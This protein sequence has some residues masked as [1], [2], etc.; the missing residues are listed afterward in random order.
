[1]TDTNK[2]LASTF[3]F[4][5]EALDNIFETYKEL[6]EKC[7][8]GHSDK[9][10][11]FWFLTKS[12]DIFKVEQDPE[13]YSVKPTMLVPS[14]ADFPMIPI[15][16][17]LPE[18]AE[19]RRILLPLFTPQ[20][21]A[22]QEGPVRDV[23]RD[24][25]TKF[26]ASDSTDAT[27][28]FARPLPTIFFSR[29]AGFPEKDWPKFDAWVD[30][31]LYRR[32]QEPER[33]KTASREV[34]SYFDNLIE[35]YKGR[36]TPEADTGTIM[37]Y[38]LEAR[39]NGQPLT[40][41]ELL[42]YCYLMFLGGLDTTAWAIRASLWYLAQNL[43]AQRYLRENPEAVPA[44]AEEF[45]RTM[46]PVQAMG[47]T[48]KVDTTIRGQEI[49]SGERVV[50]L[51]G[52]GNR[53]PEVYDHPDEIQIDRKHNKH[54]AFG[55]GHHRCLGS[56]LGRREVVIALE[57]FLSIVPEFTLGDTS[58][59]WHGVGRLTLNVKKEGEPS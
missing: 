13:T 15:D 49:K 18:L 14:V 9:Y 20:A 17:D 48:C 4:H 19:Y 38:L 10:G 47:R 12:D 30:D 50:L 11:G 55:A 39:I 44:A 52:A 3:D 6:R 42:S 8:V 28:M 22:K 34:R 45:L 5:G 23:A 46:A 35:E 57:E 24:L 40:K 2:T 59:V 31:I 43:E 37:D 16:T 41:D 26:A 56:N 32:T 27:A 54:L 21:L 25:A 51:F 29:L 53:D 7:P 1:M 58:E 33:A 36:T